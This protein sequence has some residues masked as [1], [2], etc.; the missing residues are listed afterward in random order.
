MLLRLLAIA[1]AILLPSAAFAQLSA[2]T[3]ERHPAFKSAHVEPR[4]VLVWLPSGYD[5]GKRYPV[6]YAHDGQNLFE[7]GNS[8]GGKEWGLDETLAKLIASGEVPPTIVVAVANTRNRSR[9]YLP[10]A[11]FEALSEEH[12]ALFAKDMGGPP[13]SDAYLRF[14]VEELK[15]FIDSRY[16]TLAGPENTAMMGSSMG[17]LITLYAL[18]RH[19]DIFGRAAAVSTH[20]PVATNFASHKELSSPSPAQKAIADAFIGYLDRT[21]PPPGAHR[22]WFDYGTDDLDSHY[23]RYQLRVDAML[24]RKGWCEPEHFL[25]RKYPGASHNEASWRARLDEILRYILAR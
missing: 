9:D 11:A 13:L 2:G 7:P 20:W 3:L 1:L 4:D 16:P 24:R 19:P 10:Q 22:I 6:L 8:W 12:R 25:S 14:I 5:S 18:T 23:E 17:G 21:L 15:P